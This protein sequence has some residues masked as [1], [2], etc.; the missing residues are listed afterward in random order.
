VHQ[1]NWSLLKLTLAKLLDRADDNLLEKVL[2][3][4]HRVLRNILPGEMVPYY[5]LRKRRH[6]IELPDK[7][8]RLVQCSFLTNTKTR[9]NF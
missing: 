9:T 5:G 7:T 6:K 2:S 1:A 3:N 4:A 8:S